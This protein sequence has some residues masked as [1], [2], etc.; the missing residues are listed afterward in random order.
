MADD[1]VNEFSPFLIE[2]GEDVVLAH[3]LVEEF[4]REVKG[5]L[6]VAQHLLGLLVVTEIGD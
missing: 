5:V 4:G 1:M 6:G 3:D 2:I